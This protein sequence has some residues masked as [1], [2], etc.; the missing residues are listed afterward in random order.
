MAYRVSAQRLVTEDDLRLLGPD[1]FARMI[2]NRVSVTNGGRMRVNVAPIYRWLVENAT[3]LYYLTDVRIDG[4]LSVPLSIA[5]ES[6]TDL[7]QFTLFFQG[8]TVGKA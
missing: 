8:L 3:G 2:R 4:E 5:F 7:V 6:E 1:Y